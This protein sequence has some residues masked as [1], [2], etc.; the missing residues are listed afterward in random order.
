MQVEKMD[1]ADLEIAII[2]NDLIELFGGGD[3]IIAM[4]TEDLRE[5]L[6][7]WIIEGNECEF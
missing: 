5:K 2:E 3:L 1:R 7:E 6:I 4:S